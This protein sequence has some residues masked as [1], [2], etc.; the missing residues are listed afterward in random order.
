[1]EALDTEVFAGWCLASVNARTAKRA[2]DQRTWRRIALAYGREL[3]LT[4]V[5]RSRLPRPSPAEPRDEREERLAN[6]V[7]ISQ[8]TPTRSARQRNPDERTP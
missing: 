2:E 8:Q 7:Q 5:S 4:P 6:L 3:A 1:L